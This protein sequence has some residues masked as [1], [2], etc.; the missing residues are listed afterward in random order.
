MRSRAERQLARD[1][2]NAEL[3][4]ADK[5]AAETLA[6]VNM[7]H[8]PYPLFTE[9]APDGKCPQCHGT[10]FRRPVVTDAGAVLAVGLVWAAIDAR[11]LVD[12]VTC[13][14]RFRRG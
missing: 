3:D 8:H 9:A 10:Q 11:A 14:K 2:R 4:A 7:E 5:A 1:A 13:G 6:G 12:C